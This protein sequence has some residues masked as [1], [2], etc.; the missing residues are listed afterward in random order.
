M[1]RLESEPSELNRHEL[2]PFRLGIAVHSNSC[3]FWVNRNENDV[4]WQTHGNTFLNAWAA[5]VF[6][7]PRTFPYPSLDPDRKAKKS[8]V[9]PNIPTLG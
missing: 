6:C 7:E 2:E 8:N 9:G 4:K 1:A 5:H 3:E